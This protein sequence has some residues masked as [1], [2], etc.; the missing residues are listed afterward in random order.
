MST[1]EFVDNNSYLGG[2]MK[3]V[4]ALVL[5]VVASAPVFANDVVNIYSFRQPFL[6]QPILEDFT[7]QT[8][9]KTNVVFAKKGLI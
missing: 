7:K 6:I 8:G 9:I 5:G 2:I 4:F 3:K 1:V